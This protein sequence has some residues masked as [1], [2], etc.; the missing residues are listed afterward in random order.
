MLNERVKGVQL[1]VCTCIL[2][3]PT[4]EKISTFDCVLA[5]SPGYTSEPIVHTLF[6][7]NAGTILS[8]CSTLPKFLN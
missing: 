5:V 3:R 7:T 4:R 6:E 1:H 2:R 8:N